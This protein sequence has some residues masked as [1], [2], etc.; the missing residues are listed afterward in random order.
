MTNEQKL[1]ALKMILDGRSYKEVGQHFLIDPKV[2]RKMFSAVVGKEEKI[3]DKK[4]KWFHEYI[5]K[6]YGS[7]KGFSEKTGGVSAQTIGF[8]LDGENTTKR[9]I[10]K[11][12]A[13]T[14]LKYEQ[15]FREDFEK[16]GDGE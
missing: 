1:I 15:M 4:Y 12:I 3:S 7:V 2:I 8:L 16:E 14:G 10:D 5:M 13:V 9:V 11:M 6:K